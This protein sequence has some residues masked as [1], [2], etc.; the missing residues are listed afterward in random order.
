V[1]FALFVST[2]IIRTDAFGVPGADTVTQLE[3]SPRGMMKEQSIKRSAE[4]G[5]L[6]LYYTEMEYLIESA[7]SVARWAF[8]GRLHRQN[9]YGSECAGPGL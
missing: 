6:P 3:H 4:S 2:H 1:R 9:Y 5:D 7:R 8:R